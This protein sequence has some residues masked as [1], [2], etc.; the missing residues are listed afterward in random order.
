MLLRPHDLLAPR[1]SLLGIQAAAEVFTPAPEAPHAQR[2]RVIAVRHA[3]FG[4]SCQDPY[5]ILD[6]PADFD[7]APWFF[8]TAGEVSYLVH[9]STW[10]ATTSAARDEL[11]NGRRKSLENV[12]I[13]VRLRPE[14]RFLQFRSR[15]PSF[16]EHL[17]GARKTVRG[18]DVWGYFFDYHN[19]D[20]DYFSK[21]AQ[22]VRYVCIEGFIRSS[23]APAARFICSS[24]L[25][26]LM[27]LGQHLVPKDG[28]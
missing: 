16:G 23:L 21:N 18:V 22:R 10:L 26:A 25:P 15:G 4:D 1:I 6:K 9:L 5:G 20:V 17:E 27:Y 2:L 24:F 14:F 19:K 11:E 7:F 28:L 3:G 12:H 13:G 8:G